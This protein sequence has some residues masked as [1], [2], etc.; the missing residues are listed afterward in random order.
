MDDETT[1]AII[2]FVLPTGAE[3]SLQA[4]RVFFSGLIT[5]KIALLPTAAHIKPRIECLTRGK[6][7]EQGGV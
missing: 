6:P 3:F 2:R 5:V 1:H 7:L 4:T